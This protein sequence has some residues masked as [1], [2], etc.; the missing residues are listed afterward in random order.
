M[1]TRMTAFSKNTI[2]LQPQT[3]STYNPQDT[4]T[5]RLPASALLDM[6]SMTL[7][8]DFV[9]SETGGNNYPVGTNVVAAP[10]KFTSGFFRRVDVSMGAT[11]V[12]L[13]GLHDYGCLS[14][15]LYNHCVPTDS[16]RQDGNWVEAQGDVPFQDYVFGAAGAIGVNQRTEAGV[17]KG[18]WTLSKGDTRSHSCM[19]RNYLGLMGG[20]YFRLLTPTCFRR[21]LSAL[22]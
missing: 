3:K 4:I 16:A 19:L 5:F 12:G 8:F 17:Q 18:R 7:K 15:L 14:T 2:R 6:A 22:P 9:V 1:L 13:T 21:S 20:T 10:P 11:S